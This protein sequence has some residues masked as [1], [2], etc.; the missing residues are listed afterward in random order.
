ME[1]QDIYTG[2]G[3]Y[4]LCFIYIELYVDDSAIIGDRRDI[5]E[6]FELVRKEFTI[7]DEGGLSNVLGCEI[8]RDPK[9]NRC[10]ILQNNL[11]NKL[12]KNFEGK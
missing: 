8:I 11:I 4:G 2:Q 3:K 9:E 10:W 7:K 5:D 6:V 1:N 12:I